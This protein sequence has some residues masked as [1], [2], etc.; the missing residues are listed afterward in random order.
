MKKIVFMLIFSLISLYAYE[1]INDKN[2]DDKVSGKKVIVKFH[3]TWCVSCEELSENFEQL[4]LE[5]LGVKV[6]DVDIDKNMNLVYRF[7]VNV[8]PTTLYL[9]DGEVIETEIGLSSVDELRDS[10]KKNL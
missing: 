1:E 3:A 8:V 4:D 6:Y 2:F 10:I 5:K 9:N 7:G